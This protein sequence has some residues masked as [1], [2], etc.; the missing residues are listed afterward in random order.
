MN[1]FVI[2]VGVLYAGGTIVSLSNGRVLWAL[3]WG[4]YGLSAFALA[5]LEGVK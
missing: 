3:V 2:A 5:A 1:Y 4:A